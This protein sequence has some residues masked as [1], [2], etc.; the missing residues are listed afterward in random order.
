MRKL[1]KRILATGLPT[2][3]LPALPARMADTDAVTAFRAQVGRAIAVRH[4]DAGS[5]NACEL[6]IH[7]ANNIYY[8]LARLGVHF[9]ASPRHAD[10][11][12]VTGPVSRHMVN[13]LHDAYAAMPAPK[14]V[15]AFGDCA[16]GCGVHCANYATVGRVADVIPVDITLPGCPPTPLAL[17][18]AL[19]RLASAKTA[20][21]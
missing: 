8:N 17:V 13:A 15:L 1:I 21:D 16:A 20:P 5:C 18:D 6:E 14:L 9:V 19:H 4:V 11:L 3:P 12:L 7:A 2:L 10:V